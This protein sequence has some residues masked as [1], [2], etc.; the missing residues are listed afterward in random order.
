MPLHE[1]SLPA[2]RRDP[3]AER[4]NARWGL[5]LFAIYVLAYASFV[6]GC[7]NHASKFS[8]IP[9]G[10]ALILGAMVVAFLYA[11]LSRSPRGSA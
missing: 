4:W 11:G 5:A 8:A 1:P 2:E 3:A 7:V 9:A 6:Y 10:M